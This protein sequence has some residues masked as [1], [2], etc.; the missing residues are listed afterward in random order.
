[1]NT[2]LLSSWRWLRASCGPCEE[3]CGWLLAEADDEANTTHVCEGSQCGLE[4]SSHAEDVKG[5]LLLLLL[6]HSALAMLHLRWSALGTACPYCTSCREGRG[7][8][9]IECH[10]KIVS[11]RKGRVKE[12]MELRVRGHSSLLLGMDRVFCWCLQV[13]LWALPADP[14]CSTGVRASGLFSSRLLVPNQFKQNRLLLVSSVSL[15][16]IQCTLLYWPSYP[17][18]FFLIVSGLV[19]LPCL[20]WLSTGSL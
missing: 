1:M 6:C 16:A 7:H 17:A 11:G 4:G 5:M 13:I 12:T 14:W 2:M 15:Q 19:I 10:L 9:G 8:A 20:I 18:L 3:R